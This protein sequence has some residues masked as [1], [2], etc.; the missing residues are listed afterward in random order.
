MLRRMLP[1]FVLGFVGFAT[2]FGAHIVAV[3]LPV[4][5]E[6]V[7]IGTAM[8]GL[9]IAAYD[10]AEIL[11]K[12]AFGVLADRQGMKKTM[13]AGIVI[14]TLSSVFY[15]FVSPRL[16]IFVRFLQGLGAAGLS[17]VSLAL[18]GAYYSDRRGSAY[19]VYNAIKGSGYV[20]SPIIGG[21]IV[22]RSNF[23]GLF[24]ATAA[25]GVFAFLISLPL[26]SVQAEPVGGTLHDDDDFSIKSLGSVFREPLLA[27]WYAIIVVNM[28][29]VSI[30]FGFLPVYIHSLGYKAVHSG[31]ILS[32]VALSYLLIQPVAGKWA[33]II[34]G[35]LTVRTGLLL[36]AFG[37]MIAP[38]LRGPALLI[39]AALSWAGVGIVW[40]NSDVVVSRLA[41]AGHLGATMGAAGSFKEFGDMVGPI[42]IGALSQAFGLR[43]GFVAGGVA[44]LLL[45]ALI[46]RSPKSGI[47][48]A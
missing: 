33:D 23:S 46:F 24:L 37:I 5:A 40:T 15:P 25:I 47:P 43:A 17:A 6:Q 9:L 39:V 10:F 28:F 13:L 31:L 36:S 3:N 41:R 11:A 19:G 1:A 32:V 22:S 45:F 48:R 4:Y 29:F 35:E 42:L 30:L 20:L 2:S 21:L 8:I 14:F 18:I 38:F 26:P 44:G 27:K 16:L 34:D 12:P 7:G